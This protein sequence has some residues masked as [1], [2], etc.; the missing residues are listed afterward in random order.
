MP[1]KVL[2]RAKSPTQLIKPKGLAGLVG[3]SFIFYPQVNFL[4]RPGRN[5]SPQSGVVAETGRGRY[6]PNRPHR[7]HFAL[8]PHPKLLPLVATRR[9][10][11]SIEKLAGRL[12]FAPI[13]S[14][15]CCGDAATGL[16]SSCL[17]RCLS[18]ATQNARRKLPPPHT[19]TPDRQL[20]LNASPGGGGGG[21]EEEQG[22]S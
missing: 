19:H 8:S 12:P 10:K 22:R 14:N 9:T 7:D 3:G 1:D 5:A 18:A 15:L 21:A 2:C 20:D 13:F 17:G 11:G 16:D 6:F 4:E